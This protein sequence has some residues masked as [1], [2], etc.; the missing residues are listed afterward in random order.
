[1]KKY[2]A[3]VY[4]MVLS[5]VLNVAPAGFAHGKEDSAMKEIAKV[6]MQSAD[7][8]HDGR[9]PGFSPDFKIVDKDANK[10]TGSMTVVAI[11]N[12][13]V[14]S[15][16][17]RYLNGKA[18][19]RDAYPEYLKEYEQAIVEKGVDKVGEL[20]GYEEEGKIVRALV[21]DALKRSKG[22]EKEFRS[23]YQ[24]SD[25][26]KDGV[27]FGNHHGFYPD[28]EFFVKVTVKD[29]A[30]ESVEI[31]NKADDNYIRGEKYFGNGKF[32]E[33]LKGRSDVNVDVVSGATFSTKGI[34]RAVENALN[35]AQQGYTDNRFP[36]FSADY[37]NVNK[38]KDVSSV[39]VKDGFF[40]RN[41]TFCMVNIKEGK[42][43][44]VSV[45][46]VDGKII[47]RKNY[48]DETKYL[49]ELQKE[50]K[51]KGLEN[52]KPIKGHER[53]SELVISAVADALTRSANFEK[54][55]ASDFDKEKALKLGVYEGSHNGF[56]PMEQF[57]VRVEV[58]NGKIHKLDIVED[59]DDNYIRVDRGAKNDTAKRFKEMVKSYEGRSDAEV[60][61]VSGA[62]FSSKG[63]RK[64]VED[65][66]KKAQQ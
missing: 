38:S 57:K 29:N 54:E 28:E 7:T 26:L 62:T 20:E 48:T 3:L 51:E 60:D 23:T 12:G 49:L 59:A 9:F 1:M 10:R 39:A 22:Y 2:K 33:S 50:I 64:A 44:S 36:G 41:G 55:F 47:D 5:L 14:E 45:R 17:V 31:L 11:K 4:M 13:K 42:I 61:V 24:K 46:V 35:Q 58:R 56:Y 63:L 16:R 30:I 15:M 40:Q 32:I 65:A 25:T 66:L 19:K 34:Q 18:L 53:E 43:D 8:Y 27:Y 6:E 52:V 37:K 21:K